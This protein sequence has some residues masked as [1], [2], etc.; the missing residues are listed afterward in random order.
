[1]RL[2][3]IRCDITLYSV[4][5]GDVIDAFENITIT[6]E[7]PRR[8]FELTLTPR[9]VDHFRTSDTV[10][11]RANHDGNSYDGFATLESVP[12]PES[13]HITLVIPGDVNLSTG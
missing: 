3:I 12:S 7:I 5:P 13:G 9:L 1:M 10:Q 8:R 11:F 2:G 6:N 4:F